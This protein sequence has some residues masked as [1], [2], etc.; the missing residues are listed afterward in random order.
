MKKAFVLL[1]LLA[2][3]VGGLAAQTSASDFEITQ[4]AH[5]GNVT[6]LRE[7]SGVVSGWAALPS[8]INWQKR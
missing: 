2:G 1:V 5:I 3:L 8:N 7:A 4:A 6:T